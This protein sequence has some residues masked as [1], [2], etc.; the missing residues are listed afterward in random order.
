MVVSTAPV[1]CEYGQGTTPCLCL[2]LSLAL[3]TSNL[4][5]EYFFAISILVSGHDLCQCVFMVEF[6][7]HRDALSQGL[8]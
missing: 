6:L 4:H 2:S 3:S 7:L 5:E 1:L 8:L